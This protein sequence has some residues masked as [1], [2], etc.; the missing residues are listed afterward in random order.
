MTETSTLTPVQ[1][2][3]NKLGTQHPGRQLLKVLE[4]VEKLESLVLGGA[5]LKKAESP[6]EKAENLD[7]PLPGN[8]SI[9]PPKKMGRPK[10]SKNK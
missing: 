10:G 2:L 9:E 5:A 8:S 4:R 3:Q 7:D 1:E 6:V